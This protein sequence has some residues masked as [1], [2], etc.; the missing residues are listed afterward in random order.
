MKIIKKLERYPRGVYTGA[1][2]YVSRDKVSFNVGIRTLEIN[3]DGSAVYGTGSGIV[4]ESDAA[5]EYD[6]CL[7]KAQVLFTQRKG[8]RLL[9]TMAW[10]QGRGYLLAR[11]HIDRMARSASYFGFP[12]KRGELRSEMAALARG[13]K[14]LV[15]VRMLLA[16]DG[17]IEFEAAPMGKPSRPWRVA[18]ARHRV[19][20]HDCFLY[21]KTTSRAAY[22]AALSERPDMDDMLLLNERGELTE[23]CKANLVIVLRDTHYTPP[24][25]SGL[26]AG[27]MR[28]RLIDHGNIKERVLRMHDLRKADDV[29]LI[30]SVRG[31]IPIVLEDTL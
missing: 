26:L 29:Y 30:N 2:G 21:H 18:V 17:G 8:I 12:C 19:R 16:E 27:T 20:S 1:V 31:R 25:S 5:S 14:G 10:R 23:S 6:E 9:E 3:K 28:G 11:E 15:R 22:D 24:V 7:A 13:L 4:W